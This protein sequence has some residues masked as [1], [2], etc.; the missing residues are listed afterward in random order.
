MPQPRVFILS[1]ARSLPPPPVKTPALSSPPLPSPLPQPSMRTQLH[2][3]GRRLPFL[4]LFVALSLFGLGFYS[5][6]EER[7]EGVEVLSQELESGKPRFFLRD[8]SRTSSSLSFSPLGLD[9]IL[10]GLRSTVCSRPRFQQPPV[11]HRG[12]GPAG[13]AA[14]TDPRESLSLPFGRLAPRVLRFDC[15]TRLFRFCLPLSTCGPAR[16]TTRSV[17]VRRRDPSLLCQLS[18]AE[19]LTDLSQSIWTR[20]TEDWRSIAISGATRMRWGF[21]FPCRCVYR[22][23]LLAQVS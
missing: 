11:Q 20:L 2:T 21:E 17:H 15:S 12:C 16:W 19:T 3:Y 5:W 23:L 9:L 22:R 7:L 13:E 10:T 1:Q 18:P 4:A 14:R 6:S 8:W